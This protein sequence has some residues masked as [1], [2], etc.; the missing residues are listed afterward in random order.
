LDFSSSL[1]K[2]Y[3]LFQKCLVDL[4]KKNI[5]LKLFDDYYKTFVYKYEAYSINDIIKINIENNNTIWNQIIW[6][7]FATNCLFF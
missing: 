2:I 3:I 6:E 5:T 4:K 7:L 1:F